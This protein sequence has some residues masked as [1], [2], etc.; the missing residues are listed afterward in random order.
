MFCH[1]RAE[2]DKLK[3]LLSDTLNIHTLDGR[4][5]K[6]ERNDILKDES[7]DVLLIQIQL[8]LRKTT[9]RYVVQYKISPW[10]QHLWI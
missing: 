3:E 1:Y 2:I 7:A 8:L 4:T 6:K 5:S 10:L 9:V